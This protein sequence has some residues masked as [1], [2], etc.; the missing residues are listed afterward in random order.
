MSFIGTFVYFDTLN[1]PNDPV[2]YG[3][4]GGVYYKDGATQYVG[5][6]SFV[7]MC[8]HENPTPAGISPN[9]AGGYMTCSS[10]PYTDKY[11]AYYLLN[12]P[13]LKW[14]STDKNAVK[15]LSGV[16]KTSGSTS[17][18]FGRV[19]VDGQYRFA[20]VHSHGVD[21]DGLWLETAAGEVKFETNFEAL[22]CAE[23][24]TAIIKPAPV[25]NLNS[26]CGKGFLYISRFKA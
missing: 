17:L 18:Y 21:Y 25:P 20:K 1:K 19:L 22:V 4:A 5:Y 16:L 9:P 10:Q 12:N 13:N 11:T 26:P 8:L 14:V 7:D 15:T 2:K 24:S 23:P 6:G 3:F